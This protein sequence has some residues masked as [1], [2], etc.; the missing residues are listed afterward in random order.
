[1]IQYIIKSSRLTMS[2]QHQVKPV[3]NQSIAKLN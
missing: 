2:S 3:I 1:M